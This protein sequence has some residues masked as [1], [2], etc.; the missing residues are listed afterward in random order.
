MIKVIILV[1][2]HDQFRGIRLD[3]IK[4]FGE[5]LSFIVNIKYLFIIR[6][7]LHRL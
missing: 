7:K 3:Q 2:A 4:I 6:E 1:V 5:D